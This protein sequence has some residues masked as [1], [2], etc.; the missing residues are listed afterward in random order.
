[1][2]KTAM[3][4]LSPE[5]NDF[6][7]VNKNFINL[8]GSQSLKNIPYNLFEKDR[9]AELIGSFFER[10]L[11]VE[12]RK[13]KGQYYTP[14]PIVEYMISQLDIKKDSTI[15]DP[16]C[17]CGSFLLT[18]Y[19]IMR[20]K[21]DKD[22]IRNIYGVDL[23]EKAVKITRACL[24]MQSDFEDEYIDIVKGNIRVGNSIVE[25]KQIDRLGFNWN[26]EFKGIMEHGGFDFVIGNPPYVTLRKDEDFDVAEAM[27][28]EIINSPVNAATLMIGRGLELLKDNG[29]LA[30]LLPKSILFVD[31]YANLR[32][33][34]ATKTEIQQI[35][36]LGLKFKDV[37]GEQ[38]ILIVKKKAEAKK[39]KVKIYV[40]SNNNT[41]LEERPKV[42]ILQEELVKAKK[43]LTYE[44]TSIYDLVNKITDMGTTLTDFVDGEIFR[45]LPIGGNSL[46]ETK[47]NG[48]EIIRGKSIEKFRIKKPLYLSREVLEKQ[49]SIKIEKMKNKKVVLQNIFSSESGVISAYD[50]KGLLTVDTVTN[51][52]VEDDDK[53]KYILALLNSKL[54]NFYLMYG[55]FNRSRLT[56]HLD[57]SYIGL[58]PVVQNMDEKELSQIVKIIDDINLMQQEERSSVK[59]KYKEIDLLVYKYYGLKK[60]EIML[61][62]NAMSKML[63]EKSAW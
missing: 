35:F 2:K 29:A 52:I 51:I 49:S 19:D 61:I 58:I 26:K 1:M 11:C 18:L 55:V 34:L 57:K 3:E 32:K 14:K 28:N 16:S 10:S 20:S 12:E 23:N 38:V 5:L 53:A 17:G 4:F 6:N 63:S 41:K 44:D 60:D 40:Y 24:Y 37:R 7:R 9:K 48:E 27:Y 33:Y 56:M 15:L 42:E 62:E 54:I 31:S 25:N 21:F 59:K 43:F 39:S 50:T 13:G 46:V 47:R 22:F 45:G 30:F 36:D 8:L